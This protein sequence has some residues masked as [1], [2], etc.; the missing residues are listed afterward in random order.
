MLDSPARYVPPHVAVVY[1]FCLV[2]YWQPSEE[3]FFFWTEEQKRPLKSSPINLFST[4]NCILQGKDLSSLFLI[5][6][7][8]VSIVLASG[9]I[10][11]AVGEM[12]L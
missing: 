4:N 10:D 7:S 5:T 3:A 6:I 1:G 2:S 11:I 8:I 9:G 12:N